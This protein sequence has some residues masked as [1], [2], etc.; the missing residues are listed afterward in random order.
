MGSSNLIFS[1]VFQSPHILVVLLLFI[2]F[3]T[4]NGQTHSSTFVKLSNNKSVGAL[5][6]TPN[7]SASY[8]SGLGYLICARVDVLLEKAAENL[9][10]EFNI[11][12]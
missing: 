3:Q 10:Y 11:C 6:G 9:V 7:L 5:D 1:K 4:E 8:E 12:Y 2:S